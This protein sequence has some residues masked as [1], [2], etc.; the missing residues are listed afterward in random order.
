MSLPNP[1]MQYQQNAVQSAG[2]GELTMMLYNGLV[3]FLMLS[4]NSME[5]KNFSG[6]H[7]NLVRAQEIISH[8]NET[9]DQEY[10]LSQNLASLYEFMIRQLV[11]ANTKKDEKIVVEV[12]ELAKDLRDT[13]QK[14]LQL[15][16]QG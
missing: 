7:N 2:P 6:T 15:V 4:L 11:E 16:K 10:E 5:Q 12:L 14:A 9:L 8:L 3:K 13:W 1:Y